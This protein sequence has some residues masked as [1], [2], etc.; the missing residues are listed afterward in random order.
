MP[1]EKDA[2]TS[3]CLGNKEVR[4]GTLREHSRTTSL[5]VHYDFFCRLAGR[6][7][8]TRLAIVPWIGSINGIKPQVQRSNQDRT[9]KKHI[10]TPN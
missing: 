3:R 7:A 4:H 1:N 9:M 6:A 8:P 2:M 10:Y 5:C